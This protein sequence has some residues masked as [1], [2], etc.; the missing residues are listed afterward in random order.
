MRLLLVEDNPRLAELIREGVSR[1]GH[2]VDVVR[3]RAEARLA[4]R[5]FD[6][7]LLLLDLGLP[8]GDGLGL[9]RELRQ[10]GVTRPCLILTARDALHDR[11]LGLDSGADDYLTKP[12]AMEELV[13][14]IHALLRRPAALVGEAIVRGRL[15][16]DLRLRRVECEGQAVE[17]PAGE[18]AAL[19]C[20]FR[21][22][23]GRCSR[24]HLEDC[25]YGMDAAVTPNAL[26]VLLHRL[27]KRLDEA[28]AGVSIRGL[29]GYGYVLEV[30]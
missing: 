16:L 28:G 21:A 25:V 2:G 7:A 20:L 19:E 23:G 12:F 22:P 8:D 6:Y 1:A 15:R 24:K 26:E 17:M 3:S 29:R 9:L 30:T 5:S 18:I 10:G 27:R 14:R 13:A 4:W 11:V